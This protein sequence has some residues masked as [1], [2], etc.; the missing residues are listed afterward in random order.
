MSI[1]AVSSVAVVQLLLPPFSPLVIQSPFSNVCSTSALTST[2][3]GKCVVC[4]KET[5]MRCSACSKAGLDWMCFCSIEHQKL[6]STFPFRPVW[7]HELRFQAV[8]LVHAQASLWR[9]LESIL[10]ARL[11]DRRNSRNGRTQHGVCGWVPWWWT[12]KLAR[13]VRWGVRTS[14]Q[15]PSTRKRFPGNKHSFLLS[16]ATQTL[17]SIFRTNIVTLEEPHRPTRAVSSA[18]RSC[19]R[20]HE[21]T[22]HRLSNSETCTSTFYTTSRP[23]KYHCQCWRSAPFRIPRGSLY[24]VGDL[25]IF[26]LRLHRVALNPATQASRLRSSSD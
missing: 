8:D 23:R 11:F 4:G 7:T 17:T 14:E 20:H 26:Q 6:V 12:F 9:T 3:V 2:S 13:Q 19:R 22:T 16:N 15:V 5:W 1:L 10:L 24:Q 25:W 21:Y 18:T